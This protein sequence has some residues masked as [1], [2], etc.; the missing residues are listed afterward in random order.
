MHSEKPYPKI[1]L[2]RRLLKHIPLDPFL[3]TEEEK[4]SYET[5]DNKDIK[6][7]FSEYSGFIVYDEYQIFK[8]NQFIDLR[9]LQSILSHDDL[10]TENE[11]H[12]NKGQWVDNIKASSFEEIFFNEPNKFNRKNKYN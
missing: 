8:K 2:N 11:I 9:S 10:A 5:P 3:E 12:K 7:D 6:D 1:G 4:N